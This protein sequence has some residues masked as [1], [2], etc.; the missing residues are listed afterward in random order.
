MNQEL[1]QLKK[2]DKKKVF[3]GIIFIIYCFLFLGEYNLRQVQIARGVEA[4]SALPV[5]GSDSAEYAQ[6]ARNI[7]DH[8][9][10]SIDTKEPYR[11]DTF[12]TVGYPIFVTFFLA[13]G[14]PLTL[15][16]L[17][18]IGI[19]FLTAFGIYLIG[20][21]LIH[22]KV[23]YIAGILYLIDPVTI[24]N[25]FTIVT[26]T[27]YVFLLV[28]SIY[29]FFF[30]ENRKWWVLPIAGIF[31]GA[32]TLVRPISMFL[33]IV[34]IGI[35]IIREHRNKFFKPVL[36]CIVSYYIIV[37]P[38]VVRNKDITGVYGISTVKS[39]NLYHYY[40]PEYL[41][42]RDKIDPVQAREIVNG[43]I[44]S[45][46]ERSL[47]NAPY[48]QRRALEYVRAEP[49]RYG[50]FHSIKTLPFFLSSGIETIFYTYNDAAGRE[51]L[52]VIKDNMTGLLMSFNISGMWNALLA[53]PLIA[54]EQ[55]LLA[56]I[57][58]ALLYAVLLA[59][60]RGEIK[61]VLFLI[62]LVGYF[63]ILTGPVAYSRYRLPATPFIFILVGYAIVMRL[64]KNIYENSRH[65]AENR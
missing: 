42:Y 4:H 60:K 64:P 50:I 23:G 45:F 7:V 2:I 14:L 10:F 54:L 24:I 3:I 15:F 41:A 62:I 47:T 20:K 48:M 65:N 38:W 31:L 37:M 55:F 57:C 52:P 44:G 26:D 19:V 35:Y 25:T 40:I 43:G 63:A 51:V 11:P 16:P 17:I 36:L 18:Q 32:S 58:L 9:V 13:L 27:L 61:K 56:L 5:M 28:Y 53:S 49:I 39:Y 59:W 12:R 21:R 46:D 6:L 22:E 34:L 29:F 30:S 1:L 8:Y 33:L